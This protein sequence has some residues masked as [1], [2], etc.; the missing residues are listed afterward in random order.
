M[1]MKKPVVLV[2]MFFVLLGQVPA[3]I[4]AMK[5]KQTARSWFIGFVIALLA[6]CWF[7][8]FLQPGM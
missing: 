6:G 7:I 2:L 8:Y 4:R 5:N 1:I 3:F